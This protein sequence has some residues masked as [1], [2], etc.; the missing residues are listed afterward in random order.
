MQKRLLVIALLALA[1]CKKPA[2]TP[3]RID[4]AQAVAEVKWSG[5]GWQEQMLDEPV[6]GWIGS[7]AISPDGRRAIYANS[8]AGDFI[9]TSDGVSLVRIDLDDPIPGKA[10]E[11]DRHPAVL[12]LP[13]EA[14]RNYAFVSWSKPGVAWASWSAFGTAD[15]AGPKVTVLEKIPKTE[16]DRPTFP[17]YSSA[18]FAPGGDC[19]AVVLDRADKTRELQAW[20]AAGASGP[21]HVMK[22]AERETIAGWE[23]EGVLLLTP[24]PIV[25]STSLNIGISTARW[26]DPASASSHALPALPAG[27]EALGRIGRTWVTVDGSGVVKA[28]P[29]TIATLKSTLVP[30]VALKQHHRWLRVFG[31]E[32]GRVLAVE[33]AIIGPRSEKRALHL[34]LRVPGS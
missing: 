10:G 3:C 13:G 18:A 33:E 15:P 12:E 7:F 4:P 24:P 11:M 16:K 23:A 17:L 6:N 27:A 25:S 29:V 20:K 9:P 22:V 1:G 28:G 2:P 26:V 5:E 31:A 32:N 8:L 19:V 34:L 14:L 21:S 30:T